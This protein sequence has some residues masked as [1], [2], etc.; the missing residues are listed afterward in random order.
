[1]AAS[2]ATSQ[3]KS[4]AV[5][6]TFTCVSRSM[7]SINH[8]STSGWRSELRILTT[9]IRTSGSGSASKDRRIGATSSPS[10]LKASMTSLRSAASSLRK[11][12][13]RA[14]P[15]DG[16]C[17]RS[18]EFRI[19]SRTAV[20]SSRFKRLTS[21]VA[22][23]RHDVIFCAARRRTVASE[24]SSAATSSSQLCCS[25]GSALSAVPTAFLLTSPI[26]LSLPASPG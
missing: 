12:S 14:L 19:A 1:M 15:I 11:L 3:S 23:F 26:V 4:T 6:Q 13:A 18:K 20:F 9:N 5:A 24:S 8:C 17:I 7:T 2:V 25:I 22:A 21:T 16:S 10:C